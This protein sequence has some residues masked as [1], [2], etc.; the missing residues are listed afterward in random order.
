[1]AQVIAVARTADLILMM[2][3]SAKAEHQRYPEIHTAPATVHAAPVPQYACA[4]QYVVYF[5]CPII[6]DVFAQ[7]HL[8]S[9]HSLSRPLL[10]KELESCGIRLNK[11]PPKIAYRVT[12][13]CVA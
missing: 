12:R 1:M 10:E 9:L 6:H 4:P 5:T 2:L 3:D 13:T 7:H 8:K 11:E